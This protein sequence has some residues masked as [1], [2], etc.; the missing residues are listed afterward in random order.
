MAWLD[1][2]QLGQRQRKSF[3]S[4]GLHTRENAGWHFLRLLYQVPLLNTLFRW[5]YSI[6]L[7]FQVTHKLNSIE[8]AIATSPLETEE[9]VLPLLRELLLAKKHL[10]KPILKLIRDRL[11]TRGEILKKTLIKKSSQFR[12]EDSH[13]PFE[14]QPSLPARDRRRGDPSRDNLDQCVN[15]IVQ[16]QV[17]KAP[18]VPNKV[19][20]RY[21]QVSFP[22]HQYSFFLL[23]KKSHYIYLR[24]SYPKLLQI[25][26]DKDGSIPLCNASDLRIDYHGWE[27]T[28]DS[29]L[30]CGASI[31]VL[32]PFDFYGQEVKQTTF[33]QQ[34]RSMVTLKKQDNIQ[35]HIHELF[36]LTPTH[37]KEFTELLKEQ[38]TPEV[39]NL[40]AVLEAEKRITILP[41]FGSKKTLNSV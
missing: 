7:F 13:P 25:L 4:K 31:K 15:S 34:A 17:G 1:N 27:G 32:L 35:R 18:L 6:H 8:K 23:N 11:Y 37:Y 16:Q 39:L 24:T 2:S 38:S 5:Y 19:Y 10:H 28:V 36:F 12:M 22:G 21:Q 20:W 14:E 30:V 40:M 9:I 29:Q 26:L 41:E 33:W 3:E